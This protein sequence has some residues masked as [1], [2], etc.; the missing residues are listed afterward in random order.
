LQLSACLGSG[1]IQLLRY[2]VQLE[3]LRL[4]LFNYLAPVHV[5]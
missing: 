1:Y 4:K 2:L 3:V 5:R